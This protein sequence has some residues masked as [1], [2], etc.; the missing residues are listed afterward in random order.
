[1]TIVA[2]LGLW[3]VYGVDWSPP[4]PRSPDDI[5]AIFTQRHS[6]YRSAR[7]SYEQWGV[8]E[9][10]Q[11]AVI[12]QESSFKASARASRQRIFGI[13]PGPRRSSASGYGQALNRTW[14]EYQI[15][16]GN[17]RASRSNFDDVTDFIGWYGQRA[18][19]LASVPKSDAYRFYLAYHEG[20]NGYRRGTW[21]NKPKLRAAA[22]KV[23]ARA[24]RYQKQYGTCRQRLA[25]YR[26]WWPF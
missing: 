18:H 21:R 20:A 6:W 13:F 25:S 26:W 9:A 5:C 24:G 10:V 11:L 22:K 19:R 4:P 2:L 12:H 1:M 14:R 16:T 17:S 8:P 15:G 3:L 7:R 23:A